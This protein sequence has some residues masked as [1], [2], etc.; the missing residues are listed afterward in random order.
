M[1]EFIEIQ[2]PADGDGYI[3]LRC[4]YCLGEFK[5]TAADLDDLEQEQLYCARCGL[6][7]TSIHFQPP[8]FWDVA[9]QHANNFAAKLLN[10]TF[11][12]I[13]A[14]FRGSQFVTVTSEKIPLQPVSRLRAITDHAIAELP[15]CELTVKLPFSQAVSVFYCP[16]C[17]QVQN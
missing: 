14:G 1:S 10:E 6:S 5:L 2:I 17:G 11:G 13:E 8:S 15:C 3:G 4:P 9:Q 7:D 16:F 12:K